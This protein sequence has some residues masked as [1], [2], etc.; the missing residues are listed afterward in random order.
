M[1][2]MTRAAA[3]AAVLLVAV[4]PLAA[5]NQASPGVLVTDVD[6]NG[7]AAAAGRQIAK[8]ARTLPDWPALQ[9]SANP[10]L[11]RAAGAR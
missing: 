11:L 9:S 7:P 3:A 8:I 2:L 1:R 6:P 10:R 4:L 5:D